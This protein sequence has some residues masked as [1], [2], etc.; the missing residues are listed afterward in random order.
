MRL[1]KHLFSNTL[2]SFYFKNLAWWARTDRVDEPVQSHSWEYS[3][4]QVRFWS[5]YDSENIRDWQYVNTY[6]TCWRPNGAIAGCFLNE[7]SPLNGYFV[8]HRES[9]THWQL[10]VS[11]SYAKTYFSPTDTVPH[12]VCTTVWDE[13]TFCLFFIV[14][15]IEGRSVD[16]PLT[17]LGRLR[18]NPVWQH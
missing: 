8:S 12:T 16:A 1:W 18:R 15:K 3:V 2:N 7:S 14:V 11:V 9:S 10:S 13:V 4:C 17:S 5:Y 6:N